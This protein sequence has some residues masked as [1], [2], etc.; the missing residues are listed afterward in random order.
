MTDDTET[1]LCAY[2]DHELEP[3]R[4]AQVEAMI[5]ADPA[6]RQIVEAHRWTS[7][8]LRDAC[9]AHFLQ[10][11]VPQTMRAALRPRVGRWVGR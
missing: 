10:S 7:R 11:D 6:L 8:V 1:L 5:A 2:A 4:M 3:D 9:T